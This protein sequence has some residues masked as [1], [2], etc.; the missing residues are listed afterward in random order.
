MDTAPASMALPTAA[1]PYAESG[2]PASSGLPPALGINYTSGHVGTAAVGV[3]PVVPPVTAQGLTLGP[4]AAVVAAAGRDDNIVRALA[5]AEEPGSAAIV[6]QANSSSNSVGN[7]VVGDDANGGTS[8]SGPGEAVVCEIDPD[9]DE[10]LSSSG[11]TSVPATAANGDAAPSISKGSVNSATHTHRTNASW[12]GQHLAVHTN[13]STS[14]IGTGTAKGLDPPV[15]G[16][17]AAGTGGDESD[18]GSEDEDNEYF[19]WFSSQRRV[20]G[21]QRKHGRGNLR[22]GR[23]YDSIRINDNAKVSCGKP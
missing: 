12:H 9:S 13:S 4:A 14:L 21:G 23:V 19:T 20:R 17:T 18:V 6:V 11:E 2:E 3:P 10:T 15:N 5:F 22:G 7:A 16:G 1:I 8:S